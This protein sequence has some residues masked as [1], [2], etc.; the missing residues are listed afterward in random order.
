MRLAAYVRVSEETENVENQ[1]FA[2]YEFCSKRG[3]QVVEVFEDVGV[4]G[5]LPPKERPGFQR[6]LEALEEAEG[7]VVYALDRIARS[8]VELVEVVKELESRGKVIL[9]VREEW[10]QQLD[11]KI[12]SLIIAVLGWAAEMEREF[13]RERTRE[14]LRRLKVQGKRLGRRPKVT[15]EAA[16]E[17]IR[18][19]EKGYTLKE[20]ARLLRVGYTT[21]CRF[22]TQSLV[23]RSLYYEARARRLARAREAA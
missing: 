19:V 9:S 13:I 21:L 1:R 15:E 14:A 11:P 22:I 4:S 12:R 17:A 23:L 18:L 20:A 16:R 7:L 3:H 5:A 8:L 10:L 2:I 6:A